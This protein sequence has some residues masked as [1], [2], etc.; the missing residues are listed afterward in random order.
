MATKRA[1]VLPILTKEFLF[2]R[3]IFVLI[4]LLVSFNS[5]ARATDTSDSASCAVTGV[6]ET[7]TG[8]SSILEI[9]TKLSDD[10]IKEVTLKLCSDVMVAR[11]EAHDIPKWEST[12]R[13][14]L[15]Y[16]GSKTDFPKYFNHFLNT[17]KN[18]IICPKY[19][20]TTNIYPPQHLFKR[21]LASGMNETYEEYFFNFE[22][23]DVDFNAYQIVDGKKETIIDWVDKWVASG[24]GDKDEL[25]D[26]AY[27][28]SDEFCAKRG[29]EL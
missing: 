11:R 21:I 5:F 2:M 10:K 12:M 22:N 24:R 26:V 20:V 3:T 16:S 9:G 13:S 23:G 7:N 6:A 28:L 17:Y 29:S 19:Q 8:L 25:L 1:F 4:T 27:S 18:Q 14:L 15:G